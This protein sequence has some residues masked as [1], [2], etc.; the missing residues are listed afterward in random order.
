MTLRIEF[1]KYLFTPFDKDTERPRLTCPNQL[2][3]NTLKGK[4]TGKIL[5]TIEV[6]DNSVAVDPNAAKIV[7]RSSHVP[8]QELP[9]GRTIIQVNATDKAGNV[10]KCSF[11]VVVRGKL[12]STLNSFTVKTFVWV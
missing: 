2:Q 7:V 10:D 3:T 12:K 8:G 1:A 9:I 6:T 5:W 4:A 11:D